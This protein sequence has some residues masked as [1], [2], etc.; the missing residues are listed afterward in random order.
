M[1]R[2]VARKVRHIIGAP[3]RRV[4]TLASNTSRILPTIGVIAATLGR[5]LVVM[6]KGKRLR[7][8]VD[9]RPFYE[10]LTGVGWYLFHLL[11]HLARD[12]RFELI[13][14]GEP[15]FRDDGPRLHVQLPSGIEH[16]GFD[17]RDRKLS[18]WTHALTRAAYPLLIWLRRCDVVFGANYFLPRALDAVARRR[19]IT[20]HDLTY[21]RFPELVQKETLESRHAAMLRELL[22][23][24]AVIC[25]SE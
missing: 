5:N 23:A 6:H 7:L 21:R 19:V 8:G 2:R 17:L 25:V 24:D 9:I 1:L 16:A 3:V 11:E 12:E 20:V 13:A 14:F 15:S 10:P 18:R 22:R 4:Q